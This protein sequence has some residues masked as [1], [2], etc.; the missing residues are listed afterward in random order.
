M[1][2]L[3]ATA[4]ETASGA[5]IASYE[6]EKALALSQLLSDYMIGYAQTGADLVI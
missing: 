3:A 2:V 5:R 4:P 6:E 1:A